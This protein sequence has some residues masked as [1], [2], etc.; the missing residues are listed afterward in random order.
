MLRVNRSA[1]GWGKKLKTLSLLTRMTSRP[2]SLTETSISLR[3]LDD[4]SFS[5]HHHERFFIIFVH[6]AASQKTTTRPSTTTTT[7]HHRPSTNLEAKIASLSEIAAIRN[8]RR[9][10]RAIT[11]QTA[12]RSVR[13]AATS[14]QSARKAGAILRASTTSPSPR[15]HSGR[16]TQ[17]S[18]RLTPAIIPAIF[19]T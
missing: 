15:E 18:N 6:L 10:H 9:A 12:V 8:A 17:V 13:Q 16:I 19:P 4:E 5:C 2:A 3:R 11:K 1:R 7:T 14:R